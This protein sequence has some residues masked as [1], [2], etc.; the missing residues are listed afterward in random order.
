M[1]PEEIELLSELTIVI[2]TYNRPLELERAIE[3]WRD[4]PVTVHIVDGSENPC[5]PVGTITGV[6][7]IHYHH[8][9]VTIAEKIYEKDDLQLKFDLRMSIRNDGSEN[10]FFPDNYVRRLKFCTTL[11]ITRYSALCADDDA[12]TV[13]GLVAILQILNK[14]ESVDA[15]IGRAAMY[16]LGEKNKWF[17]RY[18]DLRNSD[19][20]RSNNVITRLINTNRAP[21]IFFGVVKT[22]LWRKLF[23]LAF[24]YNISS[25]EKLLALIGR[26]LCRI[27]I[28][29]KI[30]WIR[31]TNYYGAELPLFKRLLSRQRIFE[32]KIM[33]Q[34]LI[35]AI[36]FSDPSINKLRV[37]LVARRLTAPKIIR[38]FLREK[39]QI[40]RIYS[41][42][43]HLFSYIPFSIR[44]RILRSLPSSISGWLGYY[45]ITVDRMN[46]TTR[47]DLEGFI[48]FLSKTD[49]DCDAEELKSFEKLLLMPRDELRL[50]A[51][52]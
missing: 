29:E 52:I 34:Q 7:R 9:P 19:V 3:Y 27:Q 50:R 1:T 38:R 24:E 26:G 48:S 2:P 36:N 49:I 32:R 46:A 6:P 12:F 21:W 5:F 28:V 15:M 30:V 13:S 42:V 41:K 10:E 44:H 17:L 20:Y 39:R 23:Q 51:N 31:Q 18:H 35:K 37:Y 8:L 45:P 22:N 16:E 14:D 25:F 11:P 47:T 33:T 40:K 43:V 4:L